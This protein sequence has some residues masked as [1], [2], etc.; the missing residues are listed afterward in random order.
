MP[1]QRKYTEG[2]IIYLPNEK[3]KEIF[4]I[5]EGKVRVTYFDIETGEE[6]NKV[7]GENDFFGLITALG[8][9]KREET[10]TAITDVMSIVFTPDEFEALVSKNVALLRKFLQHFSHQIREL[11]SKVKQIISQREA[12]DPADELF[13]IGEYYQK[14]KKFEQ[15]VYAYTR[16][17]EYYPNGKLC[18]T[19]KKRIEQCRRGVSV[20]LVEANL[21]EAETKEESISKLKSEMENEDSD[22]TVIAKLI[23]EAKSL[24]SE[25]KFKDALKALKEIE[26]QKG[27]EKYP[28][29][30]EKV[31]PEIGFCLFEI[32]DYKESIRILTE[33]AKTYQNNEQMKKVLFYLGRGYEGLSKTD[34]AVGFYKK[35][36]SMKPDNDPIN[37]KAKKRLESIS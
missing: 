35:I 13:N 30:K 1:K 8:Y 25:E 24:I 11:G 17:T 34:K 15:A 29:F 36:L 19:A 22:K 18:V 37:I 4:L 26:S 6:I 12:L 3:S 10:V 32:E 20:G 31:I 7:M 21:D 9:Y 27:Y 2:A 33:F 5:K 28:E 23:Y 14:S 16:Y